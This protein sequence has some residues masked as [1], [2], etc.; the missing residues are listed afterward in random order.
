MALVMAEQLKAAGFKVQL[1][2]VDWATL[3]QRRGDPALCD[4]YI[5]HSGFFPS[6][7]C[8]PR[9]SATVRR[10]G[11]IRR[12]RTPRSLPSMPKP[13]PPSAAA[14]GEGAGSRL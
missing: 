6:L 1:D 14:V 10:A 11:G 9:S 12:P 13:T 5:T 4:V 8:R 7:C 3:V 2:V